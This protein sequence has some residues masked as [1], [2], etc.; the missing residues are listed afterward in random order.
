MHWHTFTGRG[1]KELHWTLL[2]LQFFA[3]NSLLICFSL[4]APDR[5]TKEALYRYA[6]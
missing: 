5:D 4:A 1:F 6:F 2:L 3:A